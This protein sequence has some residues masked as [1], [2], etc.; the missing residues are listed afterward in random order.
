M[1][2]FAAD[3]SASLFF[4]KSSSTLNGVAA[5]FL[6]AP[7]PFFFFGSGGGAG[8][9]SSGGGGGADV[10]GGG[11]GA[12]SDGGGGGAGWRATGFGGGA[13]GA[14]SSSLMIPAIPS[15]CKLV[16]EVKEQ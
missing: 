4:R 3:A 13:G 14:P 15:A 7:H 10:S 11:G 5:G 12:A 9:R 6:G 2:T 1:R 8:C 16:L